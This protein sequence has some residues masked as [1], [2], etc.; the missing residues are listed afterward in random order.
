MDP[1]VIIAGT[2]IAARLAATAGVGHIVGS[3]CK[4]FAPQSNLIQKIMVNAGAWGLAAVVNEKVGPQ[5]E[6]EVDKV[7]NAVKEIKVQ[8]EKKASQETE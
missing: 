1:N 7:A 5:V 3:Y 8:V 6:Q 4:T 2:K